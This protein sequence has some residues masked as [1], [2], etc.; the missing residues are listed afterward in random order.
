MP[1]PS[2]LEQILDQHLDLRDRMERCARLTDELDA[3]YGAA[4]VLLREVAELR[5][6]FA[7]HH[8]F[9]EAHL[10]PILM[11]SRLFDE[12]VVEHQALDAQITSVTHELRT[13]LRRMRG[14]LDAEDR[15]FNS[16][17]AHEG[18]KT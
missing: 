3:G 11:S 1:T 13:A 18:S 17:Y 15:Y 16:A 5:V 6:V 12:H 2:V 9:E 8:R 10:R 14:H 4:E 7:E